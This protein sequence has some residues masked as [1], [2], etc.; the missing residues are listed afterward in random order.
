MSARVVALLMTV[1]VLSACGENRQPVAPTPTAEAPT[2]PVSPPPTPP[3]PGRVQGIVLDFQSAKPIAGAVVG[4]ATDFFINP[5]GMTET[6]VTDA[7]GRYSLTEP[8]TR[9]RNGLPLRYVFVV[10]NQAVGN[11]YPRAANYGADVA[12]DKG[13]CVARYGM[14]LDSKTFA[15]IVGATAR[16]L[17]NQVRATTDKDGWYH[18]DWGCG[19]GYVGFNTTWHIMSHPDYTSSNFASGRGIVGNYREDVLLTPR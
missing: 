13:K 5:T 10:D 2:I 1:L 12:V 6:S 18:I 17:S 15:P 14:V 16:N 3:P 11:G 4:F 7:N 9:F 19:V 8:P